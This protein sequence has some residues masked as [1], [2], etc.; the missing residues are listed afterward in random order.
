VR[1]AIDTNILAY[2]ENVDTDERRNEALDVLGRLPRTDIVLPVQV[3]GELFNVLTLKARRPHETAKN[4]VLTWRD[5]FIVVDTTSEIMASATDLASD[6]AMRIWDA[7]ILSAASAAGC[8]L[9]L[10]EDFQD[11]FTWGG[12]TVT[13]AFATKRHPLLEALLEGDRTP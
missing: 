4:A 6:H 7:V 9:L 3:L 1:I 10:S 8:R 12:V 2:A 5:L 13:N 11:G